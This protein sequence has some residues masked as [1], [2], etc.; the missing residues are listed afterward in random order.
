DNEINQQIAVE[1]L[2]DAGAQVQVANNGREAVEK[3]AQASFDLILMDLQMPVMDGYQATA[4]IRSDPRFDK[5]PIIAMTAHA[6][7]EERQRC[8]DAGMVDHV[9]KPVDP[10]TLFATLGRHYQPAP[11][12]KVEAAAPQSST[13]DTDVLTD[14]P[15][16]D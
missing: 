5:V 14:L 4:K 7:V 3:V 10:V 6:T 11:G 13:P 1:L 16:I 12:R 8:L 15:G 9:S 2:E